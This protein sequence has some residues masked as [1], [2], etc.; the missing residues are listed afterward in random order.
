MEGFIQS[1][2]AFGFHIIQHIVDYYTGVG[3]ILYPQALR[4]SPHHPYDQVLVSIDE[5]EDKVGK[6]LSYPPKV[7]FPYHQY[8]LCGLKEVPSVKTLGSESVPELMNAS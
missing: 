2:G 4:P 7:R 5:L 1:I 3:L 6:L 8:G